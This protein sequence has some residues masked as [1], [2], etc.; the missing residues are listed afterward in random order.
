MSDPNLCW[1][2]MRLSPLDD[3]KLTQFLTQICMELW[4]ALWIYISEMFWKTRYVGLYWAICGYEK[5]GSPTMPNFILLYISLKSPDFSRVFGF[6]PRPSAPLSH[7]SQERRFI[8]VFMLAC[9]NSLRRISP[10]LRRQRMYTRERANLLDIHCV[11]SLI[12]V[13]ITQTVF[14]QIP[15]LLNVCTTRPWTPFAHPAKRE[16]NIVVYYSIGLPVSQYP[17]GG[18]ISHSLRESR[19]ILPV[20][21][22]SFSSMPPFLSNRLLLSPWFHCEWIMP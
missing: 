13:C 11:T 7:S 16:F 8:V 3:T 14:C 4:G 22:H 20:F 9:W 12:K 21:C 6:P 5:F 15:C 18:I 19:S 10:W 1:C 17:F 2:C